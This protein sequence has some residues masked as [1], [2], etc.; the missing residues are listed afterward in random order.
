MQKFLISLI[1]VLCTYITSFSQ[2]KASTTEI[3]INV[4]INGSTV[5][6]GLY[7]APKY[8]VGFNAGV[9]LDYYFSKAWSIKGKLIYDQK[10]W[11][12]SIIDNNIGFSL[13]LKDRLD[14]LIIPVLASWHFGTTRNW[15]LN[16]GPYTG[17]LLNAKEQSSGN[18]G[19][20]YFNSL[21]AGIDLGIGIKFPIAAKTKLFLE[22]DGQ[23]S[24][25]DVR[26]NT[27]SSSVR[28]TVSS[29]N[30]GFDF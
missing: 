13:S 2:T 4:G 10:G 28:N 26:K 24:V 23:G 20:S 8:K 27:T 12:E 15:Y 30:V 14:Y 3:G 22:I 11:S 18:D 5:T 25:I 29:F 16:A 6:N 21:D 17:I 1:I 9:S 19:K 7:A